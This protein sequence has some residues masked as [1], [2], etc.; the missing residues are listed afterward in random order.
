M[1][2]FPLL[3]ASKY[4]KVVFVLVMSQDGRDDEECF[5]PQHVKFF[6]TSVTESNLVGLMSAWRVPRSSRH[7]YLFS[8]Y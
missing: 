2:P 8:N 7:V 1:D 6:V 5:V 3:A 4:F